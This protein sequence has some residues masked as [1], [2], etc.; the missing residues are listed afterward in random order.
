MAVVVVGAAML[1]GDGVITPAISVISAVEGMGVATSAAQ[2]WI[3]PISLVLVVL[4]FIIQRNGT[5]K[6]G[7][8]F[9]PVMAL[10]FVSIAAAGLVS[11]VQRP[12]VLWAIDPRHAIHFA[13]HNGAGGFFVLGGVV[14]CITGVEALYADLSHFGRKPIAIAWYGLVWPSVTLCYLGQGARV[15]IDAHA[16]DNPFYSLVA[17]PLLIPMVLLAAAAT[18]IASQ[19]LISGAF[20]LDGTSDRAATLAAHGGRAHLQSLSGSGVRAGDQH[21]ARPR[22]R[23]LDR[24][25]PVERP[26]RRSV[27]VSGGGHHGGH[28]DRVLSGDLARAPLEPGSFA[29][30]SVRLP[31]R[32]LEFHRRRVAEVPRRRL[33]AVRDQ[34]GDH[35]DRA[36]LAEGR[37]CVALSLHAQIEPVEQYLAETRGLALPPANGTMVFLTGDP[38]G[39][40]FMMKHKWLRRRAYH[41]RIVLLN[42]ARAAGPYADDARRVNIDVLSDRLVRVIGHFGYMEPP[43]IKQILAAC[44]A[45]GLHLEDPETSFFYA[46]PKLVPAEHGMPRGLRWLFGVL[47]RNSRP[48][49]DDLQIPADRRVEIGIEVGI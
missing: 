6:V 25:V 43:R 21:G 39:V 17:G 19:A 37:R 40:P 12:G 22:L 16:F 14:L 2:P 23:A 8:L 26:A 18:I 47:A 20:T 29:A 27:R 11:I 10:W 30:D 28:V 49:P 5:E 41:E 24:D 9:G 34:R 7:G 33:R 38:N 35:D 32:R 36:D 44:G 46:D 3:V 42:L 31:A 13:T 48:L 1:F 4:L 15:L 45:N